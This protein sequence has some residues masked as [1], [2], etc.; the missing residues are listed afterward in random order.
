M[1]LTDEADE[2]ML[3]TVVSTKKMRERICIKFS[4]ERP[5]SG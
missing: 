2:R 5:Q 4:R 3:S 1:S